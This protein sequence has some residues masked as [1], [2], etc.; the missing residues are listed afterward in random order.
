MAAKKSQKSPRKTSP[1]QK[2]PDVEANFWI[3][4]KESS[5][6]NGKF[7]YT[8]M[9]RVAPK[10]PE[11][12]GGVKLGA[13]EMPVSKTVFDFAQLGQIVAMRLTFGELLPVFTE[14]KGKETNGAKKLFAG[15]NR[16]SFTGIHS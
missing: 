1:K 8:L 11:W 15:R 4:Q 2:H 12:A 7:R 14:V 13:L 6:Q 3:V 10:T 9:L 5:W 16:T